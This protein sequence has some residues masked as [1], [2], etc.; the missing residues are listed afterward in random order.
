VNEYFL[1]T[2][3]IERTKFKVIHVAFNEEVMVERP[4]AVRVRSGGISASGHPE[5]GYFVSQRLY[6]FGGSYKYLLAGSRLTLLH[7]LTYM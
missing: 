6:S 4:D 1:V 2:V 3:T 5:C 7:S